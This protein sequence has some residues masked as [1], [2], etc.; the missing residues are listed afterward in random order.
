MMGFKQWSKG[1]NELQEILQE[2]CGN[3]DLTDILL[4]NEVI[5][6]ELMTEMKKV[7][8]KGFKKN[9][10]KNF[11]KYVEQFKSVVNEEDN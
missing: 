5:K 10:I 2:V 4:F 7:S 9:D 3:D 1:Y 8:D 11:R 6:H